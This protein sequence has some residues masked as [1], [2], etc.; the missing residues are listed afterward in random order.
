MQADSTASLCQ[1]AANAY[2]YK[3][4]YY[5]LHQAEI[6]KKITQKLSNTLRL[7]FCYL[8]IVF[9]LHIYYHP[10][11]GYILKSE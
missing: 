10:K 7:H 1:I 5:K 9:Y 4:H 2:F 8:K 11:I 6:G 3:Q